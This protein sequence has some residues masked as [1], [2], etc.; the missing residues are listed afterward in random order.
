MKI[1]KFAFEINWPLVLCNAGW[2]LLYEDPRIQKAIYGAF[3]IHLVQ[4]GTLSQ[5]T[6]Y[7]TSYTVYS[8]IA[9]VQV[10]R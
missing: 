1:L 5:R 4:G 8:F 7:S 10:S 2:I 9:Q 6:I 3:V